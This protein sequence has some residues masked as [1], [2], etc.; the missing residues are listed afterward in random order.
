MYPGE[1]EGGFSTLDINA[2]SCFGITY[3]VI[4][5]LDVNQP[6]NVDVRSNVPGGVG[7]S[8]PN[9]SDIGFGVEYVCDDG[10]FVTKII[11]K[12]RGL[13]FP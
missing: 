4:F 1:V 13:S 5:V 12:V 11:M 2:F 8:I 9:G 6:S 7:C 3:C 10:Y